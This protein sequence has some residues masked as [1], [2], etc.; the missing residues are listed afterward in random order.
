MSGIWAT[1]WTGG[2]NMK[3]RSAIE[4]SIRQFYNGNLPDEAIATSDEEY[5]YTLE[6]LENIFEEQDAKTEKETADEV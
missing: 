2:D 6:Y 3:L 4:K 5:I 1:T